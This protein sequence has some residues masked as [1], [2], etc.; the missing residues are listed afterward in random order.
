MTSDPECIHFHSGNRISLPLLKNEIDRKILKIICMAKQLPSRQLAHTQSLQKSVSHQLIQTEEEVQ[1]DTQQ[2][3]APERA[4]K[5]LNVELRRTKSNGKSE[6][7]RMSRVGVENRRNDAPRPLRKPKKQAEAKEQEAV[8]R[9]AV[10][11][12]EGCSE[13]ST[14]R[15][16]V[17]KNQEDRIFEGFHVRRD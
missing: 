3:P 16:M 9:M 12:V 5:P 17:Q 1:A 4:L 11:V 14:E 15:Q 2:E 13:G 7:K 8:M 6:A 10:E